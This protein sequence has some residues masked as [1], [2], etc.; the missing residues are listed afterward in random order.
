MFTA[1]FNLFCMFETFHNNYWG[2]ELKDQYAS[3]QER[4]GKKGPQFYSTLQCKPTTVTCCFFLMN[5]TKP[6]CS[7]SPIN[8]TFPHPCLCLCCFPICK[9]HPTEFSW[10]IPTKFTS[11]KSNSLP[12]SGSSFTLSQNPRDFYCPEGCHSGFP[13]KQTDS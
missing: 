4:G 11:R 13:P 6:S 5:E 8:P 7:C 9:T 1:Q 2:G 10:T 12:L 3:N